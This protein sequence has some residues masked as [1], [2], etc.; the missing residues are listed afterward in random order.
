[1]CRLTPNG[2]YF[3]SHYPSRIMPGDDLRHA[4]DLAVD[5]I[6]TSAMPRDN[7]VLI[8]PRGG[9]QLLPQ[10][11]SADVRQTQSIM[12]ALTTAFLGSRISLRLAPA[13]KANPEAPRQVTVCAKKKGVR[14]IV[15]LECTEARGLGETPS[16]YTTQKV[17]HFAHI[18]LMGSLIFTDP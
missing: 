14:C 18:C 2:P 4:C 11:G 9:L 15:T 13:P 7:A 8:G 3:D 10:H 1:M 16:R 5:D 6:V 12:Q 17:R